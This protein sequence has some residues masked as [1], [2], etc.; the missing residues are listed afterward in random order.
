MINWKRLIL[1]LVI[2]VFMIGILKLA[3]SLLGP[4]VYIPPEHIQIRKRELTKALDDAISRH[5]NGETPVIDFSS[6][7][8]TFM[9]DRLY[10]FEPYTQDSEIDDILGKTWNDH[11][12]CYTGVSYYDG[13]M[14]LVFTK[15]GQ[16]VQC[17]DYGIYF[18]DPEKYEFAIDQA[19]F[20]LD[21]RG[22]LIWVGNQ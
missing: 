3:E 19:R 21:Q 10:V 7:K 1:L 5:K 17:L 20:I 14:L 8:T 16:V 2:L 15:N 4:K 13:I 12:S 6:I 18:A 22:D 11:E 9:W